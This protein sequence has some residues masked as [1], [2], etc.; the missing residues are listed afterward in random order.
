LLWLFPDPEEGALRNRA[1]G[2]RDRIIQRFEQGF[3]T[4]V[5]DTTWWRAYNSIVEFIDHER[6]SGNADA[7]VHSAWL[8]QGMQLKQHALNTALQL[9]A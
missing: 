9:A 1:R 5:T 3:G 8:G 2:T 7:R 6:N 4:D